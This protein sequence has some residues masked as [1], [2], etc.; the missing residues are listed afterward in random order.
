MVSLITGRSVS[1]HMMTPTSGAVLPGLALACFFFILSS[2]QSLQAS[3]SDVAAEVHPLEADLVDGGVGVL[4]R[5]AQ[6]VAARGHAQDAPAGGDELARV[7]LRARMKD[8]DALELSRRLD[9][10]DGLAG[11]GLARVAGRGQHHAD[12]SVG[13]PF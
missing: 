13:A 1:D 12:G 10:A 2:L 7:R 11:L 3:G 4:D 9:A 5:R 6:V 8:G